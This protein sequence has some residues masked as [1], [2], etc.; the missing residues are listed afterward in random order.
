MIALDRGCLNQLSKYRVGDTGFFYVI[1]TEGTVVMHSRKALIGSSFNSL[2]WVETIK[3]ER[4]GCFKYTLG[5]RVYAVIYKP[6][7]EKEILCLSIEAVELPGRGSDC[8]SF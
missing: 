4:S 7:S 2:A 1:D 6:L 3:T 5:R 8:R